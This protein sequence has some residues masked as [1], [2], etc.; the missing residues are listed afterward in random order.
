MYNKLWFK[1]L[2]VRTLAH[3]TAQIYPNIG[4]SVRILTNIYYTL[5]FKLQL[6]KVN[7]ILLN[8]SINTSSK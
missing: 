6:S 1:V 3:S 4:L 8:C 2:Q 5:F 7:F